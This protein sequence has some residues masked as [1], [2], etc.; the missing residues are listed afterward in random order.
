MVHE[1]KSFCLL[2]YTFRPLDPFAFDWY[3]FLIVD[4]FHSRNK[5]NFSSKSNKLVSFYRYVKF[6]QIGVHLTQWILKQDKS[7]S[8]DYTLLNMYRYLYIINLVTTYVLSQNEIKLIYDMSVTALDILFIVIT[9]IKTS[10]KV[11]RE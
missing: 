5:C 4:L 6:T 2:R 1:E 3:L 9:W 8:I 10:S 7:R 11:M